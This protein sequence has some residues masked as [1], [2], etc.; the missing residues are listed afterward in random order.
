MAECLSYAKNQGK[1]IILEVSDF[2]VFIRYT[3]IQSWSRDIFTS[4]L[5]SFLLSPL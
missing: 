4:I 3:N 2:K 5:E 1:G